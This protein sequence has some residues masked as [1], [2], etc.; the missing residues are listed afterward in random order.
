MDENHR[1][2]SLRFLEWILAGFDNPLL[3]RI[4]KINFATFIFPDLKLLEE[5][6]NV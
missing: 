2:C 1:R 3:N 6:F 5:G 4:I